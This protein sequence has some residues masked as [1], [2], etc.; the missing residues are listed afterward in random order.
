M[1]YT[2]NKRKILSKTDKAL[3]WNNLLEDGSN[4]INT[5]HAGEPIIKVEKL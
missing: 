3:I 5:L 4:N 2:S 1:L